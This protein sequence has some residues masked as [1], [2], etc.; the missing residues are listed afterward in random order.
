MSQ[1]TT[2]TMFLNATADINSYVD[3]ANKAGAGVINPTT[4][5]T[6]QLLDTIRLN[7]ADYVYYRLADVTP[8]GDK[9]DKLQ[10]RRWAP[11]QAHTT[12]LTE[13]IPPFSDKGSVEKY[14]IT[15]NQ[16][17]RY[18]EFTDKVDFKVV[19]PIIANYTREYSLVAMETLDML[20][21][22][23]LFSIA[24]PYY[25]SK[26]SGGNRVACANLEAMD[27]TCTP[28]MNDLRV[29]VLDLKKALVKPRNNGR[30]HV[31]GSPE[32]FYDMISD[33][34][35]EKYMSYN[36]TTKTM[37]EDTRL[38]PMFEMEF[39]EALTVPTHGR[40]VKTAKNA[41]RMIKVADNTLSTI[42]EDTLIKTGEA[43]KVYGTIAAGYTKDS[44]TGEDASWI[45]AHMGFNLDA[46]TAT[47]K[48]GAGL[49]ELKFQHI[50]IL[51]K[52]ALT[53]TGLQG[54]DQV[55]MYVKGKGESGVIDP[56]DQRQSV[57]FK[58]NSVGFGSTR[59]EAVADYI[60]IPTMAN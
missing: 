55:R 4:F 9:A 51:G 58:I 11:L 40:F 12:P 48:D 49:K 41:C 19:D 36:Q 39:Y 59:L 13:G 52:D 8:I 45:P 24:N 30:Y 31:I 38:V 15:A 17:G 26:V 57:G 7:E 18:M 54:E 28:C 29:I 3:L 16:Y 10:L 25:A 44:R 56:I 32:F 6:K 20:A 27:L 53:R 34:I 46:Y 35:V 37:Y 60:C 22:E 42:T 50:L 14:E 21:K 2:P 47:G 1:T 33:P 23:T 5:Y 43:A